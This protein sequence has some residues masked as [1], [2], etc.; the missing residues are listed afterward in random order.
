M[1]LLDLAKAIAP[2]AEL[3]TVGIRPG[4]KLHES[5]I[6]A[7]EASQARD[8]S[9]RYVIVPAHPWWNKDALVAGDPPAEGFSY[10]SDT[11]EQWLT[12]D[13]LMKM[14]DE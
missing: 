12:Q 13:E 10:A 2:E 9:D 8:L 11:N 1:K 4:E 14:I 5:L 6:S 7:D 3:E